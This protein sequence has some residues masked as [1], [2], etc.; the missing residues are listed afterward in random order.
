MP[1][2]ACEPGHSKTMMAAFIVAIRGTVGQAVLL[3]VVRDDFAHCCRMGRRLAGM[4]FGRNWNAETS[5]PYFQVA[6]AVLIVGVAA[7]MLWRNLAS[8][9]TRTRSRSSRP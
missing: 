7:W 4:Y 8:A 6:S 3:G 1:C 2:T 5:E 9:A